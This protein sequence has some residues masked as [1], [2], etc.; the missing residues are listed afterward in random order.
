MSRLHSIDN[1]AVIHIKDGLNNLSEMLLDLGRVVGEDSSKLVVDPDGTLRV[2][3]QSTTLFTGNI[4]I[5]VSNVPNDISIE[6]DKSV[7][8]Q[9]KKFE[10]GNSCRSCSVEV[11]TLS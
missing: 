2:N 1:E 6:T 8:F 10:V 9:G 5:G 11:T 3:G 7:K 4:G